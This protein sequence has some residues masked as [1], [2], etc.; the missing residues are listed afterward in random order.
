VR[1]VAESL[2]QSF[3]PPSFV[4]MKPPADR[5]IS[6]AFF[7][8]DKSDDKSYVFGNFEIGMRRTLRVPCRGEFAL[9]GFGFPENCRG[10]SGTLLPRPRIDFS[11]SVG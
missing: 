7:S 4:P 3:A 11:N 5:S 1:K 8:T 2:E 9:C 10:A 6:T